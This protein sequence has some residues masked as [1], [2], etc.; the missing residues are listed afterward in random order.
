MASLHSITL[1]EEGCSHYYLC[2]ISRIP[3][4]MPLQMVADFIVPKQTSPVVAELETLGVRIV[5]HKLHCYKEPLPTKFGYV[6]YFLHHKA[7]G[8]RDDEKIHQLFVQWATTE[9]PKQTECDVRIRL[10]Q[11]LNCCQ[12]GPFLRHLN[13]SSKALAKED[14]AKDVKKMETFLLSHL[15]FLTQEELEESAGAAG[16]PTIRRVASENESWGVVGSVAPSSIPAAELGWLRKE[17]P[18]YFPKVANV[19]SLEAFFSDILGSLVV[20]N[21]SDRDAAAAVDV[22][23]PVAI[24]VPAGPK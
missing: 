19:S 18:A 8:S 15:V 20:I 17:L 23:T 4:S 14:G 6:T 10:A 16:S 3:T 1:D 11:P 13:A 9:L 22:E 12:S 24:T 21:G 2:N 5:P 7:E